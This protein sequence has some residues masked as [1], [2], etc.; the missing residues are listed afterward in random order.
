MQDSR[1]EAVVALVAET[2]KISAN[3]LGPE[4][5]MTNT[6]LWDSMEHLEI[7]LAFEKRFKT[8]LDVDAISTA[9]SIRALAAILPDA[10]GV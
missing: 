1:I 5:S 8:S 7:C 3:D 9:T 6:P 2:L 4:S 10:S